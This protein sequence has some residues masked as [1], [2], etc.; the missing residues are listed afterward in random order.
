MR[1]LK[2]EMR[3]TLRSI[4]PELSLGSDVL[5]E[6]LLT[7]MEELKSDLSERI[8]QRVITYFPPEY[9]VFARMAFAS[10]GDKVTTIIWIDDPNIPWLAG[11]FARHA[12]KLSI[13]ILAHIVRDTFQEGVQSIGMT[14]NEKEARITSYA[15][16]RGWLDPV[17]LTIIV[18]AASA[19]YWLL[20]HGA[21]SQAVKRTLGL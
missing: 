13:P 20:A 8:R 7:E 19:G 10:T 9:T 21:V 6:Q 12:W 3:A 11:L 4:D 17:I 15:P 14:I 1:I 5:R 18:A 2:I 16:V